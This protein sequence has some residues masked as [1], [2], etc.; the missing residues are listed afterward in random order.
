MSDIDLPLDAGDFRLMDRKVVEA[1]KEIREENRYMRGLVAWVGFN[2]MALP[3]ERD[4]RFAGETKYP[5]RKMLHLAA[6]GISSF[7]ER[8][9]RLAMHFG[10]LV[11]IGAFLVG[12][13]IILE[14][15]INPS[16]QLPGYAS[17][18]AVILFSGGTQL[19]AIGI[20]GQYI[21]RTY[22]EVKN[23]PLYIVAEKL[24][25]SGAV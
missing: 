11:T 19:M 22:R 25:D 16:S 17:T 24:N 12:A 15:V 10:A 2:Q 13:W 23:R 9:L 21:G 1:L 20:L 14:K 3:Y 6:D 8:P 18:M 5:L 7:S 4:E